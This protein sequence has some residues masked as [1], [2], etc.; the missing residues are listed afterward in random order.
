MK[1]IL[2]LCYISM[3]ALASDGMLM[4]SIKGKEMSLALPFK[5]DVVYYNC[6]LEQSFFEQVQGTLHYKL[7]VGDVR[8]EDVVHSGLSF[9]TFFESMKGF[10]FVGKRNIAVV[11]TLI[12]QAGYYTLM[13]VQHNNG[14]I[15]SKITKSCA[16]GSSYI[17]KMTSGIRLEFLLPSSS[18][19]ESAVV[20]S[21]ALDAPYTSENVAS[22]CTVDNETM[23]HKAKQAHEDDAIQTMASPS[24]EQQEQIMQSCS[25]KLQQCNGLLDCIT[26]HY[27]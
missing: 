18:R 20:P 4:L 17:H 24:I 2:F 10:N 19:K 7:A 13:L 21:A 25:R 8:L 9:K 11:G 22:D 5:E 16:L 26:V 23:K 3:V 15:V 27:N 14:N 12:K 1:K 6:L